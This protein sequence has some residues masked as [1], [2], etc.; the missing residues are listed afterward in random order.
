MIK[1]IFMALLLVAI[2]FSTCACDPIKKPLDNRSGFSKYLKQT[3]D[4][5][6]NEDWGNAKNSLE[7][8]QKAWKQIK[9]ILQ[10]DID[11]DYVNDIEGDFVKLEGYIDTEEK[12]D[13]LVA[14]LSIQDSW[15]NIDSL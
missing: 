3:E 6:R 11:H 5:I 9:P 12:P 14:I 15:E 10:V 2:L 13:S 4:Y 8:S 7:N 1:R